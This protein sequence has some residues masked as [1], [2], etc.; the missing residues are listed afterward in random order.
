MKLLR[1]TFLSV[2][3]VAATAMSQDSSGGPN[4]HCLGESLLIVAPST[5]QGHEFPG[6]FGVLRVDLTSAVVVAVDENRTNVIDLLDGLGA[7]ARGVFW[8]QVLRADE[9][10]YHLST[11]RRIGDEGRVRF[12]QGEDEGGRTRGGR[13]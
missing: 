9:A 8:F 11:A 13:P 3:T 7:G 6:I 5:S 4:G 1:D 12:R 10:G 2:I